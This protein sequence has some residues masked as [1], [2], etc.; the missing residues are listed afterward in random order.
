MK[1]IYYIDWLRII[2]IAGVF[3]FHNAHFFD[4]I[5][6]SVSFLFIIIVV[7]MLAIRPFNT[8]RAAFGMNKIKISNI[9]NGGNNYENK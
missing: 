8:M 5:Y 2:A 4:P 7:Y 3:V 9:N 1:R 6:I